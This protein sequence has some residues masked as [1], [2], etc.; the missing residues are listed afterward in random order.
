MT[1][2]IQYQKL[3]S[4]NISNDIIIRDKRQ[5]TLPRKLCEQLGVEPGDRLILNV[6]GDRLVAKPKKSVALNALQ[7]LHRVF[8]T[9]DVT[10]KELLKTARRIRRELVAKEYGR[11]A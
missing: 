1:S 9:S 5:I 2:Y 11:K 10:E 7:E 3:M 4:K 8:Q 6:E